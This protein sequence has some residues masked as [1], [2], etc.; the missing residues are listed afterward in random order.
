M[1]N[2]SPQVIELYACKHGGEM[3]NLVDYVE[4]IFDYVRIKAWLIL[5]VDLEIQGL[6]DGLNYDNVSVI[7]FSNSMQKVS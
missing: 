7:K 3:W 5:Q 4:M 1:R 2:W 6:N